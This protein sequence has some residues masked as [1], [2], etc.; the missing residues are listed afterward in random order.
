MSNNKKIPIDQA[1]KYAHRFLKLI[2]P[3]VLKAEI[4]GSI[5]REQKMVS[6]VEIVCLENP[7]NPLSNLFVKGF[8]GM[9]KNGPRYKQFK[10]PEISVDLFIPIPNDYGRIFAI[11]TG[12]AVFSRIKLAGTWFRMGWRGCPDGLRRKEEMEQKGK[13]WILKDEF[14][15]NPTLPP[16]FNTEVEFFDFLGIPWIDPRSRSWTD[17]SKSNKL[18]Y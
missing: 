4:A 2:E 13:K 8:K 17:K 9:V 3:Y 1:R 14:K 12:N 16:A 15:D 18:N 6:D 11:R 7:K 5:R 10:Y